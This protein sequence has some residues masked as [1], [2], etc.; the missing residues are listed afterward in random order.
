MTD[1]T[2]HASYLAVIAVSAGYTTAS[3]N[4]ALE[5]SG[6]ASLHAVLGTDIQSLG[7]CSPIRAKLRL[8]NLSTNF[9]HLH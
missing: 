5:R 1:S 9:D 7:C 4:R 6:S 3:V 2:T 8:Q